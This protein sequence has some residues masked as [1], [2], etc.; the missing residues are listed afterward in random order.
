MASGSADCWSASEPNP[1]QLARVGSGG[2]AVVGAGVVGAGVV[3][4]GVVGAGVVGAG[5]VGE[6]DAV[7]VAVVDVTGPGVAGDSSSPPEVQAVSSAA[8][9]ATARNTAVRLAIPG[10]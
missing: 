6:G 1:S 2:A 9:S 8:V 4:A 5:V 7:A 3:G 10:R